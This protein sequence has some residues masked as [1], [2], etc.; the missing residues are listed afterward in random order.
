TG[1][2]IDAENLDK[3]FDAFSQ[4]DGSATRRF[5]GTG[6]GLSISRE[7]VHLMEGTISVS[8]EPGAG[9][10]FICLIPL[11][12]MAEESG[13]NILE[14][15]Q[16]PR[17]SRS[18]GIVTH[19]NASA[20]SRI[21]DS[22]PGARVLVVEDCPVNQ[23]VAIAML[24][25]FGCTVNVA[26]HGQAAVNIVGVYQFDIVF[27]D[28]QMPIVDGYEATRKIRA[29]EKKGRLPIVAL[30]ANALPGDR[31][32]CLAAGMDD[33]LTKPVHENDLRQALNQW[34]S[35]GIHTTPHRNLTRLGAMDDTKGEQEKQPVAEVQKDPEPTLDHDTIQQLHK[36]DKGKGLVCRVIDAFREATPRLM[37]DLR[38]AVADACVDDIRIA[39]HSMKSSSANLG[40][41]PFSA[42]CKDIENK[43]RANDIDTVAQDLSRLELLL[44]QML[45]ELDILYQA[46]LSKKTA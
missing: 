46:S 12:K 26:D 5:G 31:E 2:G 8:S 30:T 37:D 23:E 36:L 32:K 22:F 3:I 17:S 45:D 6:L 34:T 19:N 27:M 10:E 16:P 13:A 15:S 38:V 24:E 28:C 11:G 35:K 39:A 18:L 44:G 33:Y 1:I 14:P 41:L 29:K 25:K 9:S 21:A 40:A 20:D 4:V 43:A 42:L 7:L